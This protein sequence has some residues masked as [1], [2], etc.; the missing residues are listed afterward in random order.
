[1]RQLKKTIRIS[2]HSNI[3]VIYCHLWGHKNIEL[4][5]ACPCISVT[6]EII[7]EYLL[8][9]T[10]ICEKFLLQINSYF[11]KATDLLLQQICCCKKVDFIVRLTNLQIFLA[12]L[13]CQMK[14]NASKSI[15]DP[16]FLVIPS[17]V[18]SVTPAKYLLFIYLPSRLWNKRTE[19]EK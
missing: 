5:E 1:M 14:K 16:S 15:C 19:R 6:R 10:K 17:L 7:R 11:F 4:E 18:Q 3:I 13:F 8:P 9:L 2:R 12:V